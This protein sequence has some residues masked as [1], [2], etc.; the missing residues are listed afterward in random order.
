MALEARLC[1]RSDLRIYPPREGSAERHHTVYDPVSDISY[2]LGAKE[3]GVA[4]LF[5]GRRSVEDIAIHLA[6]HQG[7]HASADTLAA[8]EKRLLALR[9]LSLPGQAQPARLRDPATGI[10]YGPLKAM[11]MLPLLRMQPE[12]LLDWI[13]ARYGWLCSRT[14]VLAGLAAIL[15]AL[16]LVVL[17]FGQFSTEA[18]ALYGDGLGWLLW[19]YPVVVASI[20]VHELGHAL[21]CR[22]YK[23]RVT[24]FGIAIYLLM[25]TGWARP[26]QGDWMALGRRERMLTIVMG[27]YAS[28]LFAAAGVAIWSLTAPG[29]AWHTLSMVMAISSSL[30]LIPTLLPIFNG[31]TYL[32]LTEYLGVPR[33]RQRAF[34]Y[35]RESLRGRSHTEQIAPRRAALYWGTVLATSL[36]WALAWMLLLSLL[37]KIAHLQALWR[38]IGPLLHPA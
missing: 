4:R 1:L 24:D 35:V 33:L 32:A 23:V 13:Y 12:A 38:W 6:S 36:G 3:L 29:G 10:S 19:H 11:L 22:L 8:F 27:P 25:A 16:G 21:S 37:S 9:L 34:Q 30:S 14:F 26:L 31:D 28:L 17:R 18:G 5:D 20:A 15:A 2:S 7:Y